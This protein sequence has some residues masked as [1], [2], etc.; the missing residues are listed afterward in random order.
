MV[1]FAIQVMALA[2]GAWVEAALYAGGIFIASLILSDNAAR[3][4]ARHQRDPDATG[5]VNPRAPNATGSVNPIQKLPKGND[6]R[7]APGI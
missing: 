3:V 2:S 4:V 6:G 7:A 1:V 5:A